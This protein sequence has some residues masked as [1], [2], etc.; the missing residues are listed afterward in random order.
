M[1]SFSSYDNNSTDPKKSWLSKSSKPE[2][3]V[4]KDGKSSQKPENL[5]ENPYKS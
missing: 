1:I 4:K 3:K 5:A 2:Y